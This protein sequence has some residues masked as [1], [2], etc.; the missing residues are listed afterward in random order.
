MLKKKSILFFYCKKI[1]CATNNRFGATVDGNMSDI[2]TFC[3][4]MTKN[5]IPFGVR[6]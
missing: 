5:V 4:V 2:D 3:P 1:L 6:F